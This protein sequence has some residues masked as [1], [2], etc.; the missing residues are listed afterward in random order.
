MCRY[1]EKSKFIE[2]HISFDVK[3]KVCTDCAIKNGFRSVDWYKD[4][5]HRLDFDWREI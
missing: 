4:N 2:N 1:C 3:V 5:E